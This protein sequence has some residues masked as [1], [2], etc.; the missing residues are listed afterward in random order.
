MLPE[1]LR[2]GV[3]CEASSHG[4]KSPPSPT[5]QQQLS[6][7]KKLTLS[8]L[9]S[10][11]WSQRPTAKPEPFGAK[12]RQG[13]IPRAAWLLETLNRLT[14]GKG[15]LSHLTCQA[16]HML[17]ERAA[18]PSPEGMHM[19]PRPVTPNHEPPP[20]F[21]FQLGFTSHHNKT[22]FDN[23]SKPSTP[24]HV[25]HAI[26]AHSHPGSMAPLVE[27]LER[28]SGIYNLGGRGQGPTTTSV[29]EW[30]RSGDNEP[31]SC[32]ADIPIGSDFRNWD[33][34]K[35]KFLQAIH[36]LVSIRDTFYIG[37]SDNANSS[38]ADLVWATFF[39]LMSE[40][41]TT[42][43]SDLGDDK[44]IYLGE[45]MNNLTNC[46]P[47]TIFTRVLSELNATWYDSLSHTQR[48]SAITIL[49]SP[50]IEKLANMVAVMDLSKCVVAYEDEERTLVK[51]IDRDVRNLETTITK[52]LSHVD[53]QLKLIENKLSR[54]SAQ[55]SRLSNP[56]SNAGET[57]GCFGL[58]DKGP[59]RGK[60]NDGTPMSQT[61]E[62]LPPM[63]STFTMQDVSQCILVVT[64]VIKAGYDI[65]FEAAKV[66]VNKFG[67]ISQCQAEFI[68]AHGRASTGPIQA[69]VV[70]AATTTASNIGAPVQATLDSGFYTLK[71]ARIAEKSN[72]VSKALNQHKEAAKIASATHTQPPNAHQKIV[73]AFVA[74]QINKI[75]GTS[76]SVL[77][78]T[79]QG[80]FLNLLFI[81]RPEEAMI[82]QLSEMNSWFLNQ[83]SEE[84]CNATLW[85]IVDFYKPITRMNIFGIPMLDAKANVKLIVE[86]V[87]ATLVT[88]NKWLQGL[89]LDPMSFPHMLLYAPVGDTCTAQVSIIDGNPSYV[90]TNKKYTIGHARPQ[91]FVPLYL[92]CLKWGHVGGACGMGGK[93]N[94][95]VL[96]YKCSLMHFTEQ[97]Q[98]FC[99]HKEYKQTRLDILNPWVEN[100]LPGHAKC[101]NCKAWG[102]SATSTLCPCW[103]LCMQPEKLEAFWKREGVDDATIQALSEGYNLE[104]ENCLEA[105][106]LGGHTAKGEDA[107]DPISQSHE[108]KPQPST[109]VADY[110]EDMYL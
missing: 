79:Y 87:Y 89:I 94:S 91:T 100:C 49:I 14:L 50:A 11:M 67:D 31:W 17:Q 68:Q 8:S 86:E 106:C 62:A 47:V 23:K 20:T 32:N 5:P 82:T 27:E 1:D 84:V 55:A 70:N 95:T 48:R 75:G 36:T 57:Q 2:L 52:S 43:P 110:D 83:G 85:S 10:G 56:L 13:E 72:S 66:L 3:N 12:E 81:A 108:T 90:E 53:V 58:P 93:F 102:H 21:L 63:P 44:S 40:E 76:N 69:S 24:T 73:Q 88:E 38:F 9:P 78:T 30:P 77:S 46:S 98:A 65:S 60:A 39:H 61:A 18:Q 71:T 105:K 37:N 97:H 104:R 99:Q 6:P 15:T 92:K 51:A 26:S 35:V 7:R 59:K 45:A 4:V 54:V 25:Q 33:D 109:A 22:R 29:I 80:S 41:V 34:A 19:V 64:M 96:C 107:S 16:N 101:R 103:K 28:P 74:A 42:I